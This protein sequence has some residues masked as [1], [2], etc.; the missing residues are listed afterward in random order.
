RPA[1]LDGTRAPG[2]GPGSDGAGRSAPAGSSA[3][4]AG[5]SAPGAGSSAAGPRRDTAARTHTRPCAVAARNTITTPSRLKNASSSSARM[6]AL[7]PVGVPTS[8]RFH[9]PAST[10]PTTNQAPAAADSHDP[11]V[12]AARLPLPSR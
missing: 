3:P 11:R 7:A 2:S 8:P 5:S 10:G 4:G 9:G 6:P 1:D 12:A